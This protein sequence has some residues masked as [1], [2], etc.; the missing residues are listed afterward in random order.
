MVNNENYNDIPIWKRN[1]E[2]FININE[3]SWETRYYYSLFN[4]N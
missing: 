3:S 1:I 4:I 2:R